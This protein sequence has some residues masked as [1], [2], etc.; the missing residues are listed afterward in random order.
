MEAE[1][2]GSDPSVDFEVLIRGPA[3]DENVCDFIPIDEAP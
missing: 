3:Y 2:F 1:E